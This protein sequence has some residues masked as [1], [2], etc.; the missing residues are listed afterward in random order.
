MYE[1]F[2]EFTDMQYDEKMSI[3]AE[4]YPHYK[5]GQIGKIITEQKY[6]GPIRRV[7]EIIKSKDKT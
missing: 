3:L 6:K 7:A 2:T 1:E 4:K 5:P